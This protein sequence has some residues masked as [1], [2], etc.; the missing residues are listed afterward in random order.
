MKNPSKRTHKNENEQIKLKS[1][2]REVLLTQEM[3]KN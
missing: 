1:E 2:N 3:H